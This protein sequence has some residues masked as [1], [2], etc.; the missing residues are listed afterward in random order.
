[1]TVSVM[2]VDVGHG[3]CA[4]V[5]DGDFAVLVDVAPGGVPLE[6]L[7]EAGIDRVD[8]VVIS[9]ADEDH[10]GGLVNL[11]AQFDVR[12]VWING[13]AARAGHSWD[14]VR[15][16]LRAAQQQ[17]KTSV[18]C[19]LEAGTEIA[20]PAGRVLLKV[21][22]P[23]GW[24]RLYETGSK[25]TGRQR[26]TANGMSAIVAVLVDGVTQVLLT[27]DAD[28]QAFKDLTDAGADLR[29][30]L[31]V[32]PHH[33]G[34][35][36]PGTPPEDFARDLCAAVEPSVVAFSVGRGRRPFPRR[37]V[38]T[39]VRASSAAHIACTQLAQPCAADLPAAD[40]AH[41]HR[42]PGAGRSGR[43][44]CAGTL[45]TT[46]GPAGRALLPVLADHRA[47]VEANAPTRM[48]R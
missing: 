37:E 33:G 42:A 41:L 35:A 4:L 27:G 18:R 8:A 31:L 11:L 29:A 6:L 2:V 28:A 26:N 32:F 25:P 5:R 13:D 3:N 1:M 46:F 9:H 45:E 21:V 34:R 14:A 22:S 16:A 19:S 17:G 30:P 23:A 38:V 36:G 39:A 47:F 44:C 24:N 48:C 15:A 43:S 12:E 40:P 7:R 10:I 20:S